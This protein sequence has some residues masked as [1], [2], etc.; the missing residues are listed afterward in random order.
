MEDV[1]KFL[2]MAATILISVL[3]IGVFVYVFNSGSSLGETYDRKQQ[4]EQLELYN[5]KFEFF[6]RDNNTIIDMISVLN[7]AYSVNT[8]CGYDSQQ[9]VEVIINGNV[10]H[11]HVNIRMPNFVPEDNRDDFPKNKVYIN[12]EIKDT[13]SLLNGGIPE[14]KCLSETKMVNKTTVYHYL[15]KIKELK[16]EHENGKVSKLEFEPIPNSQW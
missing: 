7:L 1:S 12:G 10:E 11:E 5:S 4:V 15:F 3:I 2:I 16:Y 6:A 13:Y 8:S 14:L 9:S